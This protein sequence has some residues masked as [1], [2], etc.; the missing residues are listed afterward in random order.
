[1][2]A[3]MLVVLAAIAA[4]AASIPFTGNVNRGVS[5]VGSV[6]TLSAQRNNVAARVN[7]ADDGRATTQ[8]PEPASLLLLGTG[9][10][11]LAWRVRRRMHR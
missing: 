2:C 7:V 3:G 4:S 8:A 10:A 5:T 6:S 1:M 11:V 9:L